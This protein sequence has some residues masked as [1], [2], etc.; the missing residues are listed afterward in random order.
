MAFHREK[1]LKARNGICEDP[2]QSLKE[3]TIEAEEQVSLYEELL[4]PLK[5]TLLISSEHIYLPRCIGI[6]S[7]LPWYNLLK[8]WLCFLVN[9][10]R[11]NSNVSLERQVYNI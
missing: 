10:L 8:D 4:C 7:H 3:L 6:L 11:T 5:Q 2:T 1:L 9:G